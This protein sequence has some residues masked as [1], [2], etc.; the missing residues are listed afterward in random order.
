MYI[1]SADQ[2]KIADQKS[3]KEQQ[4]SSDQLMERAAQAFVNCFTSLFPNKCKVQII[5]GTGNNG[6][7][8]LVIARLLHRLEYKPIVKIIGDPEKGSDDFKLNYQ[9]LTKLSL[10]EDQTDERTIII[11]AL[12]GIGLNRPVSG[13]YK[14]AIEEINAHKNTVVSVDIPSGLYADRHSEGIT[15]RANHTISFEYPKLAFMMPENEQYTG[16]IHIVPIG[17]SKDAVEENEIKFR[18]IDLTS[19]RKLK[20]DRNKFDHKGS[21]GHALVVAG[22]KG[23]MGAALLCSKAVLKSG[24][25]LVTAHIPAH[26]NNIFQTALWEAMTYQDQLDNLIG[27]SINDTSKY[28]AIGI[29][30]GIGM[31]E[32]TAQALEDYLKKEQSIV[33]DADALNILG[34]KQELLSLC[35]GAVLCPHPKEFERLFGKTENN[36]DRIEVL[37]TKAKALKCTIILKGANTA[38]ASYESDKVHFNST[39]NNGMATAGSGDVLTGLITGLI[40]QGYTSFQA[41]LIG[42]YIHGKAGDLAIAKTGSYGLMASDIC[43]NIGTALEK[44][45]NP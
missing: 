33:I 24:A 4:I 20:I 44:T 22:K 3:I 8:G 29:G 41:S 36:F 16:K 9:R 7:D 21:Y 5:C 32:A 6:G 10:N 2:I 38:I 1:L 17:L 28:K 39:G 31:D 19:I 18:Q 14:K 37:K 35:E 30:P 43:D 27:T 34:T 15:I 25:G 23:S 13:I 40:A 12:F 42:V 26:A 45:F 11:D